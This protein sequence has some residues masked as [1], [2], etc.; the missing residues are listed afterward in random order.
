MA[1]FK[2]KKGCENYRIISGRSQRFLNQLDQSELK[3]LY[4]KGNPHIEE[5]KSRSKPKKSEGQPQP[6]TEAKPT[7]P[8]E[9]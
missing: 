7:E 2:V 5:S 1:K 8:K 6:S 9:E 4:E 3:S